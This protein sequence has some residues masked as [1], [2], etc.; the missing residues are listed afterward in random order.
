MNNLIHVFHE[1]WYQR[2]TMFW[3]IWITLTVV[4][5]LLGTWFVAGAVK[6]ALQDVKSNDLTGSKS[7]PL[8]L[9]RQDRFAITLFCLFLLS[10]VILLFAWED[11]AYYDNSQ[12]TQ[13]TLKHKSYEPPIW[14]E[15]GR[16]FPMDCQEFN[17]FKD[18]HAGIFAYHA[19]PVLQLLIVCILWLT[20]DQALSLKER[21]LLTVAAL[22]V[23]GTSIA[24]GGLIYPDRN[25]VLWLFLLLFFVIRFEKTQAPVWAAAAILSA[26]FMLY[27]KETAFLLLWGFAAAR[28]LFRCRD[29]NPPAWNFRRFLTR[30]SRLDLCLLVL[31]FTF[32]L[33]YGSI[34][35]HHTNLKY[36]RDA[37]L[38][39]WKVLQLYLQKDVL[40]WF[41]APVVIVRIYLIGRRRIQPSLL[42]DA[43]SCGA[44]AYLLG[45]LCLGMV[46]DYYLL[47][48][49]VL[50]VMCLGR[51]MFLSWNKLS[52]P[53]KI[54][55]VSALSL[56]LVQNTS[57]AAYR[58]YER[59]NLI[60]AKVQIANAIL[61][62]RRQ[63]SEPRVRL[64]FPFATP[65]EIMEFGAY[66]DYR[67]VPI[68]EADAMSVGT[69]CVQ[70]ISPALPRT[71]LLQDYRS[72][73]GRAGERPVPGDL[74]VILPDDI[75]S[76]AD[77]MPYL[78]AGPAVLSY[79]PWPNIPYCFWSVAR[80]L[81]FSCINSMTIPEHWLNA[82]ITLW[83]DSSKAKNVS[84][85]P[86]VLHREKL[87]F[88]S[89]SK[90]SA[91]RVFVTPGG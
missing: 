3:P 66:L 39:E 76:N 31:G 67:G 89:A 86:E 10:Y 30:E 14:R 74:V 88:M 13:Y 40:A 25:V 22:L 65:Y 37:R 53:G 78:A 42:W 34:M 15:S 57:H 20:L 82:S 38:P 75:I 7:L 24:F 87:D 71:G 63:H 9:T 21:V 80:K 1:L 19:V 4:A 44:M 51:L 33:Y 36:A 77:A 58:L 69:N 45:F 46:S 61:E 56:V 62:Y 52:L 41:F 2:L 27:Y 60:Q 81:H 18:W 72:I 28:L 35:F 17:L 91:S 12:F 8:K 85:T 32:L 11:F 73:I 6:S 49:D 29:D 90:I 79:A 59:K 26:Q 55:I 64:F 68:E 16:F 70:L 83:E 48:V 54:A 84:K 50:A 47:P 5:V 43:L 23:P